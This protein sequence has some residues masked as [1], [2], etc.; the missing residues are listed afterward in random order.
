[1]TSP[2]IAQTI[3]ACALPIKMGYSIEMDR[4]AMTD[5]HNCY[6]EERRNWA[7]KYDDAKRLYL[8]LRH[9]LLSARN[10]R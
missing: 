4:Y 3:A 9:R 5:E 1:M 6:V 7:H 2:Y 8:V 10:E